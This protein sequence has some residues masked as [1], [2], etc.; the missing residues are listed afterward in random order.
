MMTVSLAGL[1]RDVAYSQ[2]PKAARHLSSA[3]VNDV[4]ADPDVAELTDAELYAGLRLRL[5]PAEG[6]G[7]GAVQQ[8]TD[9]ATL[10][11]FTHD[12]VATLVVDTPHAVQTVPLERLLKLDDLESLERAATANTRD[13]LSRAPVDVRLNSGA[14]QH[15]GARFWSVDADDAPVSS[16]ASS[17]TEARAASDM[18]TSASSSSSPEV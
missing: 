12:T 7:G 11:P 3:Y 14:E 17:R 5:V 18:A 15:P 9:A 4:F 8:V 16:A 13:E 6:T 2:H 1:S 10:G